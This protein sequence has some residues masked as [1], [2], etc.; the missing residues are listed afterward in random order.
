MR[1]IFTTSSSSGSDAVKTGTC[2]ACGARVAVVKTRQPALLQVVKGVI[3][4]DV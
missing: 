2:M 4:D 3:E 1:R